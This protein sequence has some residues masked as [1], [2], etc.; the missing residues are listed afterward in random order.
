MKGSGS[1]GALK[2]RVKNYLPV[3]LQILSEISRSS[4]G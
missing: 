4:G 3:W 1:M 2:E